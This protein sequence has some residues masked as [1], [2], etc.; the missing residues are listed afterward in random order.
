MNP[1]A[2]QLECSVEAEVSPTFAWRFRTDVANWKDPPAE[3]ALDGAFEEGSC[4]TTLMPGQEPLHWRITEVRPG[5]SFVMEMQLDGATLS[6]A[7][8]F[9]AVAGN[10]TKLTQQIVL[11]GDKA[12]AYAGQVEA[13]FGPNLEGGMRRI[14]AEMEAAEKDVSGAH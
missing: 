7:W 1:I 4:G 2:L 10:R 9:E 3:F 6:F 12:K 11:A 13:G 5:K 14:A 8:R